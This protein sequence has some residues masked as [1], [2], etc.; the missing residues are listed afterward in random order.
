MRKKILEENNKIKKISNKTNNSAYEL[1]FISKTSMQNII[2]H[3]NKNIRT[4]TPGKI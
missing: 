4:I 2:S 3:D 1:R